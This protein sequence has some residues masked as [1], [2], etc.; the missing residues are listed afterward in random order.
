MIP[1]LCF[2]QLRVQ[3]TNKDLLDGFLGTSCQSLLRVYVSAMQHVCVLCN[4][5]RRTEI[6]K[7]TRGERPQRRAITLSADS[8]FEKVMKPK[9]RDRPVSGSVFSVQSMTSPNCAKYSL[10]SSARRDLTGNELKTKTKYGVK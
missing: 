6:M 9:P 4:D 2:R 10:M 8:E 3:A 5:L 7:T 1:D